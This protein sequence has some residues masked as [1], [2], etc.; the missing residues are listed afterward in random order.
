MAQ[1]IKEISKNGVALI[2]NFEGFSATKY[3]DGVGVMTIGYG[4]AIKK[5]EIFNKPISMQEAEAILVK[6]LAAVD[7]AISK[8][9]TVPLNQNQYDAIGS[10]IFNLGA[11]SFAG[12]TLLKKLNAKD[13]EGASKEFIR[14][15]KGRVK[16]VLVEMPG[17]TRRRLAEQKLFTT[18]PEVQDPLKNILK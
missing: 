3:D 12:S 1:L 16:G 10:F 14:W 2:K 13:Y 8:W 11:G 7:A 9:V 17:L 15:N 5:A 18:G 4:H 6:D